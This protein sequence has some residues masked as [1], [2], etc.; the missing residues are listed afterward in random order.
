MEVLSLKDFPSTSVEL[1]VLSIL[2]V[3][4]ASLLLSTSLEYPLVPTDISSGGCPDNTAGKSDF[5]WVL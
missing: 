5:S 3:A 1:H 2:C 4:M